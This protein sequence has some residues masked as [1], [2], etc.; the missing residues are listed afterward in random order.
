LLEKEGVMGTQGTTMVLTGLDI[1]V[2]IIYLVAMLALGLGFSKRAGKSLEDYFISGRALPWWIAGTS[3][4]ATTFAADTPLAVTGLVI[5]DG[6]AGNWVWWSYAV[7]GMLTVFL[8]ARLWRRSRVVTDVELVEIRY[9]G[10]EASF[11]RGFRALYLA[12]LMNCL[13]VGWV[14]NAMIKV[15]HVTLKP[16]EIPALA[17]TFNSITH[18]LNATL[19]TGW[20]ITDVSNA[21]ILL[22]LLAITGL[23]SAVSGLWG[24]SVTDFA[25]FWIAMFGCVALAFFAMHWVGGMDG[26]RTGLTKTYGSHREVMRF[27][28]DFFAKKPLMP[29]AAFFVF[30]SVTWWASWYPGAEPGG[31]GYVVQ[32]MASCKNEK[33][34][35]LA[36]L[37]FTMAHYGVRPWPWIIV[38]LVAAVKF[39]SLILPAADADA[40]YPKVMAA[41]LPAGWRGLLLVAFFAAFMSTISTQINWGASYV[42]NDFY[43]RFLNPG[44]E[45]RHYTNVSRLATVVILII[46]TIVSFKITSVAGAWK[47]MLT[48]GAGTG[49]V[50]LLRWYW[51][52]INAWS[53]ISSMV[54]SLAIAMYLIYGFKWPMTGAFDYAKLVGIGLVMFFTMG[55]IGLWVGAHF[56]TLRR[57]INKMVIVTIFVMI[58]VMVFYLIYPVRLE[59]YHRILITA[60][61]TILVWLPVT[62]LTRPVDKKRLEEFYRLVRPGGAGWAVMRAKAPDVDYDKGIMSNILCWILGT[63]VVYCFLFGVGN[64]IIGVTGQ[65]II[66]LVIGIASGAGMYALMSKM[67]WEKVLR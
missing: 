64:L 9:S 15:L 47:L 46:G 41:V 1:W 42:V 66:L 8:Y 11:L 28:P 51:W 37:W 21:M 29:L 17:P 56:L 14:S 55:A 65:G 49:L 52:R 25:M 16:E 4:V 22:L 54:A 67:G 35:L 50:F 33:H 39:P 34:S 38:A 3:M 57:D 45:A 59:D 13:I 61:S 27:I 58:L 30:I 23:F 7:G 60:I 43:K 36:T 31:G 19:G 10:Q 40:G 62:F 18:T 63:I 12:I 20:S 6:I 44:A 24:V 5:K 2:I 32:R 48:I 53:E 26:L